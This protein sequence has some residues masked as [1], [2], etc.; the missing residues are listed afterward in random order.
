MPRTAPNTSIFHQFNCG[1]ARCAVKELTA[2]LGAGKRG[3]AAREVNRD[4]RAERFRTIFS[5]PLFGIPEGFFINHPS[6]TT[7]LFDDRCEAILNAFAMKWKS[8]CKRHDYLMTLTT[9][10]WRKLTAQ[11][12]TRHTLE[13]CM[14]CAIQHA[15]LQE[16]FPGPTFKPDLE[17]MYSE[18]STN[19]QE[20]MKMTRQALRYV[21]SF[22]EVHTTVKWTNSVHGMCINVQL[23]SFR[24]NLATLSQ[25]R[26]L[27]F[28]LSY[29]CK[30]NHHR[31]KCLPQSGNETDEFVTMRALYLLLLCLDKF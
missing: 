2:Q 26:Q 12:R 4:L 30:R 16:C 25:H 13:N 23:P 29:T 8:S 27:H 24:R 6:K 17:S 9:Q 15:Q 5:D 28:A 20:E 21:N 14:A 7:S 10:K 22:H 11:E 3:K 1:Y 31:V 19:K 18:A